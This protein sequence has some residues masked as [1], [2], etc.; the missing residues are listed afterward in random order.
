L[1]YSNRQP[2]LPSLF[3]PSSQPPTTIS[4]SSST[5]AIATRRW[6]LPPSLPLSL[7]SSP[8]SPCKPSPPLLP[9]LIAVSPPCHCLH[10]S[11]PAALPPSQP[12]SDSAA[13]SLPSNVIAFLVAVV[14]CL[15]ILNRRLL[16][17]SSRAHRRRYRRPPS[18][19]PPHS[20]S[21][22]PTV[23]CCLLLSPIAA[24]T[25]LSLPSSFLLCQPKPSQ[26]LLPC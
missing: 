16:S 18:T 20:L 7:L 12:S 8:S 6:S 5:T 1:L 10:R 14:A 21:S 25:R 4:L 26:P 22:L 2:S 19:P 13:P 24:L 11:D 15:Y 9:A 3:I 23:G 17:S